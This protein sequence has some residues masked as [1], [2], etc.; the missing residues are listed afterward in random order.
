LVA[1]DALTG[2]SHARQAQVG[3]VGQDGCEQGVLVLAALAG[4]QVGEC[5]G[6]TCGATDFMHHLGNAGARQHRV[7]PVGQRVGL[8]RRGCHHRGDMQAPVTQF[9]P[10]EF[11]AP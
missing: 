1:G 11:T 9:D 5:G 8:R 6:E 3:S 2:R 7:D 4:T 10:V